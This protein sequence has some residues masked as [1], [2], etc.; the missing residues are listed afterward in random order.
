MVEDV[1]LA[2]HDNIKVGHYGR[3]GGIIPAPD[4]IVDALK[5]QIIGG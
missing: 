5:K 2:V 3:M 1:R 4:E